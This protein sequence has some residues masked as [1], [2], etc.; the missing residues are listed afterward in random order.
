MG[1]S[2]WSGPIRSENGF[3]Y[4]TKAAGTGIV[5]LASP[6]TAGTGITTG[7]GT[8]YRSAVTKV[9]GGVIN[10]QIL[11]DLTGLDSSAGTTDIIGVAATA[12]CH[13]GQVTTAVN[14]LIL[15]GVVT[16]LELPAGGDTDI[17]VYSAV[18]ATGTE[19][20][21]VTGLTETLLLNGGTWALSTSQALLAWPAADEYLY[22]TGGGATNAT[23]TAGRFLIELFGYEA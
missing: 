18:E 4:V 22:L 17:D 3:E 23:Y 13:L 5:S 2:T 9:G 15:G 6:M 21:A 14:G 20:A 8:I 1:N 10:T 12:N 11:L 16:C 19:D 7:V